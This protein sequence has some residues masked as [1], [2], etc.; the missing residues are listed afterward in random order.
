MLILLPSK[1]IAE[2]WDL[3]KDVLRSSVPITKDMLPGWLTDSLY[4]AL[5][6]RIHCWL[7]IDERAERVEDRD[8]AY[9]AFITKPVVDEISGQQALLIYAFKVYHRAK[10]ETRREDILRLGA[11]ARAQ[12]YRRLTAYCLSEVVANLMLK[13][14][15]SASR[16]SFMAVELGSAGEVLNGG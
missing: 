5:C 1:Q 7:T 12:G 10:K 15:P 4:L 13:A 14:F 9:S 11:W 6:G 2:Q 8:K 16:V 3:F